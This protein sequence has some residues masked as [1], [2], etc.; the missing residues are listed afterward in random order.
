MFK[1]QKMASKKG[2]FL[3][4]TGIAF[5]MGATIF[6]GAYFG[7]MLDEKYP[8]D[9]KWFTLGLTLLALVVSMYNILNQ[10]KRINE[11]QDSE[12]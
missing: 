10:L 7:K 1:S 12:E 11:K 4:F 5:Q 6:L 3:V 8:S 9:K 2:S